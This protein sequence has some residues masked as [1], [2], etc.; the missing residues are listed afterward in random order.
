MV[1]RAISRTAGRLLHLALVLLLVSIGT[2]LL[3]HVAPGD[4]AAIV[5]GP[6]PT[7]QGVHQLNH[8][9][10]LDQ[11]LTTQFGRWISGV[12][13]HGNLGTSLIPPQE[14]VASQIARAFPVSLELAVLAVAIALAIA[15]PVGVISAARQDRMFDRVAT[16]ISFGL[17]AIP[18]F[19]AALVLA[20]VFTLSHHWLPRSQWS[21]LTS[22]AGPI[23]N[24]RHAVLPALTLALAE[25]A[26]YVRVLR[27]DL[28][29]TLQENFIGAATAT[30]IP[31]WRVLLVHALR[32]SSLSPVTLSGISLGR[33]IGGTVIVEV[34]FG[35]PGLGNLLV[36]AVGNSDYPVVQGV[37]LVVAVAYV[38]IN[39]VIN[40]T[41]QLLDPRTRRGT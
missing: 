41:Y 40:G 2:F 18:P 6:N 28:I 14:S 8:Q 30:G 4:P 21:D 20:D 3:L 1:I 23:Q 32:P 31:R 39:Q 35:L 24:L 27:A 15:I 11:P 34:V 12:L 16:T 17:L 37:V 33:L 22:S 5:L 7:P 10:G 36:R 29:R 9:L 26:L 25:I 19:V 13:V 38:T